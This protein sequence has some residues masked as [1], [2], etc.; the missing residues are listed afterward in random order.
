MKTPMSTLSSIYVTRAAGHAGESAEEAHIQEEAEDA[1][2][3]AAQLAKR[4][5]GRPRKTAA[6]PVNAAGPDQA[7]PA[8]IAGT[9][10]LPESSA[11][12]GQVNTAAIDFSVRHISAAH[13]AG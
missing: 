11:A 7:E 3:R 6:A 9:C 13:G 10:A 12:P 2:V 5:P 8:E 4:R 1:P